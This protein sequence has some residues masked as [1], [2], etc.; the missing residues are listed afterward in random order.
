MPMIRRWILWALRTCSSFSEALKP[1]L[2][3]S[4]QRKRG[5]CICLSDAV[6]DFQLW[7]VHCYFNDF[8]TFPRGARRLEFAHTNEKFGTYTVIQD[9]TL[10]LTLYAYIPRVSSSSLEFR[11]YTSASIDKWAECLFPTPHSEGVYR[12]GYIYIQMVSSNHI[13]HGMPSST[14][15]YSVQR[16]TINQYGREADMYDTKFWCIITASFFF[17]LVYLTLESL[18]SSLFSS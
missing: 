3:S 7:R 16:R 11:D 18:F 15:R 17:K 9:N 13:F 14:T 10:G 6:W 5:V 12:I 1:G 2:I 4:F 8:E